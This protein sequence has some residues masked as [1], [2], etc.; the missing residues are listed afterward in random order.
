M[1]VKEIDDAINGLEESLREAL[2]MSTRYPYGKCADKL[3]VT[4]NTLG[5]MVREAR[6]RVSRE[7]LG[8]EWRDPE[9]RRAAIMRVDQVAIR[10]Q[11]QRE[12]IW[13]KVVVGVKVGLRN[14]VMVPP[15]RAVAAV[16]VVGVVC[17]AVYVD[18]T[19]SEDGPAE[20]RNTEAAT[21]L[22][23]AGS[24]S[25]DG[26]EAAS[27]DPSGRSLVVERY[28]LEAARARMESAEAAMILY[29]AGRGVARDEAGAVVERSITTVHRDDQEAAKARIGSAE[30][31]FELG[32]LYLARRRGVAR[33]EAEAARW[34]R[35]AGEL[36][37]AG[38]QFELGRLY[39]GGRGV[40]RDDAAALQW[41]RRAAELGHEE[42][43]REF[44]NR[45]GPR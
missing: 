34:F 15:P 36:G 2:L 22:P 1:A 24:A 30:A 35:R 14:W 20:V 41:Y 39:G 4:T 11:R 18:R 38:A 21:E 7:L 12:T 19:F 3:G 42:A 16:G 26:S 32:Q 45:S 9:T 31:A 33:D 43:Q 25:S 29:F 5:A 6:D 17:L 23:A 27:S 40:A 13:R 28:D 44:G 37:H 10:M 8:G